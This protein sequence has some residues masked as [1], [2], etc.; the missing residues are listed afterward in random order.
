MAATRFHHQLPETYV[1]RYDRGRD[2]APKTEQRL[3]EM[4][5]TVQP[6][7]WGA[8]GDVQ[9]VAVD[10]AG[11]VEAAAD[12]RGRGRAEVFEVPDAPVKA[13]SR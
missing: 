7:W 4:G 5:Y 13:G 3:R 8:L 12:P 10:P 11:N 1:I 2:I 6:N 9:L